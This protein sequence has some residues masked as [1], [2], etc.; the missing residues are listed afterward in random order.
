[1]LQTLAYS[2]ESL[3]GQLKSSQE[4][5]YALVWPKANVIENT[6]VKNEDNWGSPRFFVSQIPHLFTFS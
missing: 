3:Y 5:I 6:K 2:Y 4:H 1:M